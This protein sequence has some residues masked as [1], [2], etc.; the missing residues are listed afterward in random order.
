M[1]ANDQ[2]IVSAV[3]GTSYETVEDMA[4]RYDAE[5][6][7]WIEAMDYFQLSF[8]QQKSYEEMQGMMN[9]ISAESHARENLLF[10]YM[11]GE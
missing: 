10:E 8:S 7:G 11:G 1:Y 2:L 6:S 5:I 4:Q 3:M 9:A